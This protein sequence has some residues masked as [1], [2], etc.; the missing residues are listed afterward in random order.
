MKDDNEGLFLVV[1][2][3]GMGQI[4][5]VP[6]ESLH[7]IVSLERDDFLLVLVAVA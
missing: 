6:Q 1:F 7:T 3:R 5:Q 4:L 2:T